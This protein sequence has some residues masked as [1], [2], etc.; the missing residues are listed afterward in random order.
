LI[1][2]IEPMPTDSAV[3]RQSAQRL[4]TAAF[5]ATN[6]PLTRNGICAISQLDK[7]Y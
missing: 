4:G 2:T 7:G 3:F 6:R 5:P 1:E